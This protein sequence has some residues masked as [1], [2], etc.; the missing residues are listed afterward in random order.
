MSDKDNP[1]DAATRKPDDDVGTRGGPAVNGGHQ[2]AEQNAARDR[3]PGGL[4]DAERK[5]DWNDSGAAKGR[6]PV[7]VGGSSDGQSDRRQD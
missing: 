4:S 1:T 5:Q 7:P 3:E 6:N 2:T